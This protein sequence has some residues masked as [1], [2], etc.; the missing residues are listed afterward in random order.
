MI[1]QSSAGRLCFRRDWK[2]AFAALKRLLA[3]PNDTVQVFRIMRALNRDTAKKGYE[4]LL[5]TEQGGRLA[6][7]CVEL[8]KRLADEAFIARFPE[9]SVGAAYAVFLRR[10]GFTAQGLA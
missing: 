9:G 2:T 3:D 1:R 6:Y 4:R 7:E 8:A 5:Q 10:T